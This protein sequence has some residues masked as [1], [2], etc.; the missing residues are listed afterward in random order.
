M[1]PPDYQREAELAALAVIRTVED[2]IIDE[3]TR[4]ERITEVMERL[5]Q[6]HGHMGELI[7]EA[8]VMRLG[9]LGVAFYEA[10]ADRLGIPFDEMLDRAEVER[11]T[12][13]G[14]LEP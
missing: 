11:L 14:G 13:L 6:R 7:V 9:A 5:R 3:T 12:E 2:D 4:K 1:L 10:K 8:M